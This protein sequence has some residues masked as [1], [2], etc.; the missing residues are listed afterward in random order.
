MDKK[1]YGAP[2]QPH[3]LYSHLCSDIQLIIDHFFALAICRCLQEASML[4]SSWNASL[5]SLTKTSLLSSSSQPQWASEAQEGPRGTHSPCSGGIERATSPSF[6]S[7]AHITSIRSTNGRD[8]AIRN[9]GPIS[10]AAGMLAST[11]IRPPRIFPRKALGSNIVLHT[12]Q[13]RGCR[14]PGLLADLVAA[15][16]I[17]PFSRLGPRIASKRSFR[18][19]PSRDACGPYTTPDTLTRSIRSL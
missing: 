8:L 6:S 2:K 10:K 19:P 15:P 4:L 5:R 7:P 1:K 17:Y 14:A 18:L 3:R 16:S 9:A 11:R 13:D 12:S